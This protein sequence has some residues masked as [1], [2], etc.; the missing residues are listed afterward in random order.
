MIS[1]CYLDLT[2]VAKGVFPDVQ[3]TSFSLPF[4]IVFWVNKVSV[5]ASKVKKMI[6]EA[7]SKGVNVLLFPELSIDLNYSQLLDEISRYATQ[8]QMYII[9]GS[10]HKKDTKRNVSVAIT[11]YGILWE[12]EKHIPATITYKGKRFTEGIDVETHTYSYLNKYE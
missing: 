11:P 9:P 4:L 6:E 2:N 1:S 12:Q 10:F 5:I 8:F 7:Q 3:K